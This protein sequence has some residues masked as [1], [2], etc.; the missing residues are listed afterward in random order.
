M[1]LIVVPRPKESA[2]PGNLLETQTIGPYP[3]PTESERLGVGSS[4]LCLNKAFQRFYEL[5][6][7]RTI[8]MESFFFLIILL[9]F[10][11]SCLYF[12]P[13]SPT[14]PQPNPPPSLASTLPVG[15]VLVSFIVVP[16]FCRSKRQCMKILAQCLVY[17]ESPK[18]RVL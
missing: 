11:Y 13:T 16:E 1:L 12:L 7:W 5:Q 18:C 14:P 4:D 8:S 6:S 3:I 10:N 2:P 17:Y 15:F 9:L